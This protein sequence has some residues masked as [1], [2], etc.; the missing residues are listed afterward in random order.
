M[1][2]F[3]TK[4]RENWAEKPGKRNPQIQKIS[5]HALTTGYQRCPERSDDAFWDHAET[6]TDHKT[7]RT[8]FYL[9]IYVHTIW[10]PDFDTQ[11]ILTDK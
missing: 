9:S 10:L 3:N 7:V 8:A 2:I 5:N 11:Y 1:D 4:L 6:L